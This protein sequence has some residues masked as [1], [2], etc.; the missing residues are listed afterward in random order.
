V[1]LRTHLPAAL[2]LACGAVTALAQDNGLQRALPGAGLLAETV[3]N[4]ATNKIEITGEQAF[5]EQEIRAP[6][7]EEIRDIMEKGVT[8]AK[9][10]DLAFYIGSFY[11]KAGYSK[12]A[13]DY[14]I[15]G[16]K[17]L[18]KINEGPHSVLHKLLFTGNHAVDDATLYDYMIGATPDQ[19]ARQP[20][21]F[22]FTSAEISAGLPNLLSAAESAADSLGCRGSSS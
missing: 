16:D 10:D 5:T 3:Q 11:R 18:I 19:L 1:K 2:L 20:A 17:L 14:E 22:P 8:P 12:V 9:A 6:Q 7:A 15:H 21:K 4:A 13:V